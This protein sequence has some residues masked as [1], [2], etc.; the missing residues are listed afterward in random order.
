MGDFKFS[1]IEEYGVLSADKY[2]IEF[3]LVKWNDQEPKYDIRRWSEDGKRAFKGISLDA[4]ELERF[5][6]VLESALEDNIVDN[7]VFK[8]E[9]GKLT[10]KILMD[11][12]AVSNGTSMQKR[13]TFCDWG[14][15]GKYDL[16]AWT[17]DYKRCG[18]GISLK[19]DEAVKLLELSKNVIKPLKKY[20]INV[21]SDIDLDSELLI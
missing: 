3:N 5:A 10:C 11:F 7:C 16:R 17:E 6:E 20:N 15:G 1:V 21:D 19:K 12:G 4:K 13:F 18:K 14:Y 2:P 9:I 8:G